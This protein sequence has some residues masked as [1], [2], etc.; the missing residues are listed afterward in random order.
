MRIEIH[1]HAKERIFER[2]IE[3]EEIVE[4]IE[5]GE[6]FAA[7]FGREG[8]RKNF[9]FAG[10]WRGRQYE[11]KQVEVYAVR[12]SDSYVVITALAKYY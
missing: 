6:R 9:P 5:K 2:G 3:S 1:P 4:T 12:E 8:F 7:K 10:F 11:M